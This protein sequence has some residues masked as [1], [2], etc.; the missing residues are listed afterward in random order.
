MQENRP[1]RWKAL[2]ALAA[3][4]GS[5]GFLHERLARLDAHDDTHATE[6]AQLREDIRELRAI[7]PNCRHE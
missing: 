2:G 1:D 4:V 6:S 5:L 7:I 3:M